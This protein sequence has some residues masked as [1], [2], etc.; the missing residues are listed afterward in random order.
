MVRALILYALAIASFGCADVSPS[1]AETAEDALTALGPEAYRSYAAIAAAGGEAPRAGTVT[2]LG[3]RGLSSEGAIHATTFARAFDDTVIVFGADGVTA[4]RFAASTHPFELRGAAGVPDVN[5]DRVADVGMIRPGVYE[6]S[7]RERLIAGAASF[8][9]TQ[10]GQGRLP[11][12]R[13]VDHD[14]ILSDDERAVSERRN[15]GLTDV[16]FH[17]GEGGAPPAVGCQVLPAAAMR[18]FTSAVGGG[19]ARFRY[20]L[21]DMTG[22]D[23]STLPR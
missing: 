3:L 16:L 17:Q 19:R 15:D 7:G 8:A 22:A 13:D 2:V 9:V 1:D 10:L 18:G 5:G 21:V 14:G 23:A 20:V 6:V 4:R 11:G 12:W